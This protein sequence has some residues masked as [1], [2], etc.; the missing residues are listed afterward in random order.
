M[1]THAL[2]FTL[3]CIGISET[4]YLIEKRLEHEKPVCLIGG[5]CG[6]VLSSKWNKIFGIHNDI[7][8]LIFY[9]V[10]G[11]LCTLLVLEIE[12]LFV[13]EKITY[14]VIG[15]GA[16]MSLYFVF[17]QWKVIKAWCFWCLMS[18]STIGLMTLIVLTSS[19]ILK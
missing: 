13:W 5:S 4:V 11:V 6:V 3:T 10:L 1:T 16:I 18:A 15:S 8:G 17:L 7:L 9:V 2:L 14:T 12:P 19:L